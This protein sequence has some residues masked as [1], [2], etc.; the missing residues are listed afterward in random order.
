[1]GRFLMYAT[2]V[3]LAVF[4][5]S[6]F[7]LLEHGNQGLGRV[8]TYT[9]D[10]MP[11]GPAYDGSEIAINGKLEYNVQLDRFELTNA[12]AKKPTP[13]EGLSDRVLEPL[14]GVLVHVNG[15]FVLSGEDFHIEGQN[16][17]ALDERPS[18]APEPS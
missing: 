4:V 15:T 18:P 13:L 2:I 11:L 5:V 1:M 3:L 17:R 16:I 14:I 9:P 12:E 7:T 6:T 10:A 8:E